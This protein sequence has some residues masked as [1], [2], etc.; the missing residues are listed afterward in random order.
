ML[1]KF[2]QTS[3][4]SLIIGLGVLLAAPKASCTQV[5]V[6]EDFVRGEW[7]SGHISVGEAGESGARFPSRFVSGAH[8]FNATQEIR[9]IKPGT[10]NCT[11]KL[12]WGGNG[13]GDKLTLRD[14]AK[15][16]S[17]DTYYLDIHIS[18]WNKDKSKHASGLV[19]IKQLLSNS[20][21]LKMNDLLEQAIFETESKPGTTKT[22]VIS[23]FPINNKNVTTSSE[24]KS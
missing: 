18:V 16:L 4:F 21:A 3:K 5:T 13:G 19:N 22:G 9:E 6:D 2:L 24:E 15:G 10:Y 12:G 8:Y 17:E 11:L 1:K 20:G 14:W 7:T 23:Y